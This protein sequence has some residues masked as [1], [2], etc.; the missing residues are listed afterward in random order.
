MALESTNGTVILAILSAK[1]SMLTMKDETI[2]TLNRT[3]SDL[4]KKNSLLRDNENLL[5]MLLKNMEN[6]LSVTERYASKLELDLD[7]EREKIQTT[8]RDVRTEALEVV[9]VQGQELSPE[10]D[11]DIEMSYLERDSSVANSLSTSSSQ[12]ILTA[13]RR[14]SRRAESAS[15]GFSTSS[16]RSNEEDFHSAHTYCVSP[17]AFSHL[18]DNDDQQIGPR[19][20]P[21]TDSRVTCTI[22]ATSAPDFNLPNLPPLVMDKF[23]KQLEAW[24]RSR[25]TNTFQTRTYR[26]LINACKPNT[27]W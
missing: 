26:G 4:E 19:K 13:R 14:R 2:T 25:Q 27:K 11:G 3:I 17:S 23:R 24:K 15:L 8:L 22:F 1:D 16:S 5:K 7:F 6:R 20:K 21:I 12:P 10:D 9:S 18:E